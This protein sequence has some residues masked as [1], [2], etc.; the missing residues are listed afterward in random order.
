MIM[1][2]ENKKERHI[3]RA[4]ENEDSATASHNAHK[5]SFIHPITKQRL[6]IVCDVPKD[7][8]TLINIDTK[9]KVH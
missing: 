1:F 2:V 3:N 5:V 4:S 8:L 9:N 7:M 6:E